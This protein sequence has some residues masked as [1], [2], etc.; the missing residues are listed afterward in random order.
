MW[1]KIKQTILSFLNP[2]TFRG[3]VA[4]YLTLAFIGFLVG[5]VRDQIAHFP[6]TAYAVVRVSLSGDEIP[7]SN[8]QRRNLG[9]ILDTQIDQIKYDANR[10]FFN[11]RTPAEKF[12]RHITT[13]ELAQEGAGLCTVD[14][15]L[16]DEIGGFELVEGE[17]RSRLRPNGFIEL[18]DKNVEHDAI[19]SWVMIFYARCGLEPD[20]QVV[21]T[22]LQSPSHIQEGWRAVHPLEGRVEHASS[23]ATLMAIWAMSESLAAGNLSPEHALTFERLLSDYSRNIANLVVDDQIFLRDYPNGQPYYRSWSLGGFAVYTLSE[24]LAEPSHLSLIQSRWRNTPTT[25][26][27]PDGSLASMQRI[28]TSD[29]RVYSDQTR[30]WDFPWVLAG[31]IATYKNASIFEK[32]SLLIE[33][34]KLIAAAADEGAL[35]RVKGRPWIKSEYVIALSYLKENLSQ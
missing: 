7:L 14:R 15:S 9:N 23:Y 27:K 6:R 20:E 34:E 17:I 25:S 3:Q 35:D 30:Y 18:E 24:M 1:A 21:S 16:F 13:W 12:N 19:M 33:I 5:V 32:A 2:N 10:G 8:K 4:L 26:I 22:F 31:N 11:P 28:V 29:G